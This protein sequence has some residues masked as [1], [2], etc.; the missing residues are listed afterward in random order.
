[1]ERWAYG[2]VAVVEVVGALTALLTS[3]FTILTIAG[4]IACLSLIIANIRYRSSRR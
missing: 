1:M 4:I 2:A 3:H